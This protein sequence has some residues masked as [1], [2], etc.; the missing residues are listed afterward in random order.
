MRISLNTERRY[1]SRAAA[2]FQEHPWARRLDGL[3]LSEVHRLY[4]TLAEG[5]TVVVQQELASRGVD[6]DLRTLQRAVA[7]LRQQ[8]RAR[9]LAIV[10]IETQSGQQFQIGHGEKLV[11]TDGEPVTVYLMA[12]VLGH[13]RRLYCWEFVAQREDDWL[14]GKIGN[15]RELVIASSPHAQ[16]KLQAL[17]LLKSD[18]STPLPVTFGEVRLSSAPYREW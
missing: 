1:L 9:A 10:R 4:C 16:L 11:W 18:W 7:P 12:A 3:T 15:W 17:N 14:E 8:H 2:G 5:N 13:S 6:I